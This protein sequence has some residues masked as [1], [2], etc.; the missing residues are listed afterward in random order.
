MEK[1]KRELP[2]INLF[3][4]ALE[5]WKKRIEKFVSI[6]NKIRDIGTK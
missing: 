3:T 5:E 4:P 1:D 6:I 2:E